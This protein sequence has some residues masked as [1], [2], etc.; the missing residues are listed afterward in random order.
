MTTLSVVIP[1]LNEARMLPD[2]LERLGS[3]TLRPNEVIVADA[4]STDDTWV[5][6]LRHGAIVT[7]GG[8]P[9]AGRNAG[10]RVASGDVLL[11]L[12]ADV[13]PTRTF[14]EKGLREFVAFGYG[15]ATCLLEAPTDR[16]ADKISVGVSNLYMRVVHPHSPHAPGFCIFA[17]RDVH[18]AIGGFDEA[19]ALAADHEYVQRAALHAPFGVLESV[20][21][22]HSMRR[23]E[24]E[25]VASLAL[26]Y[27]WAE[28]H[29]LAR[30]PI[31]S[32]PFQ[33][34]FGAY[35]EGG[36]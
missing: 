9:S 31:Y 25:G 36:P 16:W 14:V 11:F 15:A 33:Y 13:M 5:L 34:E 10:A 8:R 3:Q 4:G 1:T 7:N 30:R 17:R 2:L 21:I 32:A 28:A 29:V 20:R 27:V 12:D 26:K 23:L 19:L 22:P 35:E 6:A 18:E 24:K